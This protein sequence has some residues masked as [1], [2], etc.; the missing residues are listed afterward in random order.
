MKKE[1][2]VQIKCNSEIEWD[3][4][5]EFYNIC[6]CTGYDDL[7]NTYRI[8][9]TIENDI[10]TCELEDLCNWENPAGIYIID[11][12]EDDRIYTKY[13]MYSKSKYFYGENLLDYCKNVK[14]N[15]IECNLTFTFNIDA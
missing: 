12:D 3:S 4:D 7:G 13:S 8:E 10:E 15:Y 6:Y 5:W 14:T 9:Y 2:N 11:Y 1:I